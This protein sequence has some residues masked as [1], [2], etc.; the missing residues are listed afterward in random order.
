MILNLILSIAIQSGSPAQNPYINPSILENL[1]LLLKNKAYD[2]VIIVGN[3]AQFRAWDA[4]RR[5]KFFYLMGEG[6]RKIYA[7]DSAEKYYTSGLLLATEM[8]DLSWQARTLD[9]LGSNYR[10]SGRNYLALETYLKSYEVKISRPDHSEPGINGLALSNE[11]LGLTYH[12][13]GKDS[14][15]VRYLKKAI[16]LY[17]NTN[18]LNRRL[19]CTN[20]LGLSYLH[21][22]QEIRRK[23]FLL[24]AEVTARRNQLLDMALKQFNFLRSYVTKGPRLANLY[25]NFSAAYSELEMLDSAYHYILKC[26]D[27]REN[28]R[29]ER[30]AYTYNNLGLIFSKYRNNDSA[31]YYYNKCR[32]LTHTL[33]Q[34]GYRNID[35]LLLSLY[36]NYAEFYKTAF[37]Y[38][39]AYYYLLKFYEL[40]REKLNEK[41]NE[42]LQQLYVINETS[43]KEKK[44]I[45]QRS[46]IQQKTLERNNLLYLSL[47]IVTL[48][49]VALAFYFQRN[50]RIKLIHQKNMEVHKNEITR[51][52]A[53]QESK[54]ID[55]MIEGQE[56]ERRRIAEELHDRL[57]STLSAAKMNMEAISIDNS[58][59][60]ENACKLI[61]KA[62]EDTRQI[63]HNLLSGVLTK[64]GL[65]A[66]LHDLKETINASGKLK[67]T[68]RTIQFDERVELEKEINLYR[69]IQE[70]LSNTL[71][72]AKAQSFTITLQKEN[73]KLHV[74]V[75]DDGTGRAVSPAGIGLKNIDSRVNKINGMWNVNFKEGQGVNADIYIPI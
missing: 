62:V 51:L 44:I 56:K 70:L 16:D 64:F 27:L 32:Q 4:K 3:K 19:A 37:S 69:V 58:T 8:N 66:A 2:S 20:N 25:Q 53:T 45:T 29:D 23:P 49:I 40:S 10:Q 46:E 48:A 7:F 1:E 12:L 35:D 55:A 17:T 59:A 67:V 26:K 71:R 52:L 11:Y 54:I 57:G 15:A 14:M 18:N 42:Q 31:K 73:Q 22:A 63:S 21:W 72:H 36:S 61:D 39:S 33:Q 24:S 50:R 43:K 5:M 47:A 30:L 34:P 9:K 65:V 38:D 6:F 75:E 74:T 28:S 68:L 41:S 13:I 60:Q